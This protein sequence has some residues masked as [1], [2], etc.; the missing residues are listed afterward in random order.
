MV[1]ETNMQSPDSAK[2][3]PREILNERYDEYIGSAWDDKLLNGNTVPLYNL[4]Y[5]VAVARVKDK[6]KYKAIREKFHVSD[7]FIRKWSKLFQANEDELAEHPGEDTQIL[8]RFRSISNRPKMVESPVRDS[9]RDAV[10]ARRDKYGFEGAARIKQHCHLDVSTSTINKVLREEGKLEEP[11]KRHRN[12]H[13]GR[14]ECGLS[15]EMWHTDFKTWKYEFGDLHSIWLVDDHARFIPGFHIDDHSSAKIVIDM[16]KAAF[17]RFGKPRAIVTDRGSEFYSNLGGKGRSAF[18]VFLRGEGVQHIVIRAHHPQ[19]NGKSERTHRSAKE[20][21][22]YFGEINS[23]E[24]A[25]EVFGKWIE[26]RNTDCPHQ[27]LRYGITA[28]EYLGTYNIWKDLLDWANEPYVE[29]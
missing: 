28:Y 2:H 3:H 5:N 10:I 1:G 8:T 13:Y 25:V 11:K 9:I 27:A 18:D 26:Y 6:W 20:E 12:L 24:D 29:A 23:L 21:I 19:S 16:C 15:N 4:R 17:K 22:P 7:G 14:Y